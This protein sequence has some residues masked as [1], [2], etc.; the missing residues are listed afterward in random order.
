MDY[1][2]SEV[3]EL[4]GA[5]RRSVQLWADARILEPVA[6]TD[7]AGTGVH[8]RFTLLEVRICAML[9]P[10]ARL[11]ATKAVLRHFSEILRR[12]LTYDR[13]KSHF[14]KTLERAARNEG[15]N[16]LLFDYHGN[17]FGFHV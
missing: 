8:R 5:N 15:R 7:A 16:Y 12:H 4:T 10:L 11:G 3:V 2:L 9:V 1:G 14:R 17:H 13:E 6:E